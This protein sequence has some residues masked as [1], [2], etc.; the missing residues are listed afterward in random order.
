MKQLDKK[1]IEDI[2]ALTP[3]QE[4]MLFHF[5]KESQSNHYF[6]QLSINITGGIDLKLFER[7]W[8]I[9]IENNELLRVV[10]Q[11]EKLK[12]PAQVILKKHKVNLKFYD[13]SALTDGFK[14][15]QQVEK[16]KRDDRNEKFDLQEVPFRIILSKLDMQRWVLIIS[17]N[18]IIFDGWSTGIILKEFVTTYSNL[19]KG[20]T[21]S[22][23]MKAKFKE[24]I[25][26]NQDKVQHE[27]E[28]K[29]W[30]MMNTLHH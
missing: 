21:P 4:G 26:L 5:L 23:P 9:V 1:N 24:F 19:F 2:L 15:K 13:F 16:I 25:R 3:M 29:F 22:T 10:F 11:W 14:R 6:V 7:A 28:E 27:E 30:K 12:K 17:Y 18:H 20:R 8:N